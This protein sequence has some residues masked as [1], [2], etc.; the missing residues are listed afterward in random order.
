[1]KSMSRPGIDN[2]AERLTREW[3]IRVKGAIFTTIIINFNSKNISVEIKNC[4]SPSGL[5]PVSDR[6]PSHARY[7]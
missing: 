1:M 4:C 7:H 6:V 3:Q 2:P 5:E